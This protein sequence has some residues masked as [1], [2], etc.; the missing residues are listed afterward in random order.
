M[1]DLSIGTTP[2]DSQ[3]SAENRQNGHLMYFFTEN[4]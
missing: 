1:Y 3:N 2:V 4:I